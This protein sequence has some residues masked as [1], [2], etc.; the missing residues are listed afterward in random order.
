MPSYGNVMVTLAFNELNYLSTFQY[1]FQCFPV[2]CS[3][4]SIWKLNEEQIIISLQLR[5]YFYWFAFGKYYELFVKIYIVWNINF[6]ILCTFKFFCFFFSKLFF[7]W[8]TKVKL[9]L[10]PILNQYLDHPPNALNWS[11]MV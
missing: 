5:R 3:E 6:Q 1:I 8:K 7:D 4:E 11:H 2:F 10:A 9:L